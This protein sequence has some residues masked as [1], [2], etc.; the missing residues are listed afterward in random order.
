VKL[1]RDLSTV[2]TIMTDI[3]RLDKISEYEVNK[4]EEIH[5]RYKRE[6][7]DD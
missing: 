3:I 4:L 1:K 6:Y 5:S 7:Y 2:N